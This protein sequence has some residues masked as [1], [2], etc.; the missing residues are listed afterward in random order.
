MNNGDSLEGLFSMLGS[1]QEFSF[2]I[3]RQRDASE[4]PRG[5]TT[6]VLKIQTQ[7]HAE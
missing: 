7:Q 2:R 1:K 4:T 5:N 3:L 6:D